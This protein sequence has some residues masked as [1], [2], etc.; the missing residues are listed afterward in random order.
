MIAR[1]CTAEI[2]CFDILFLDKERP[3]LLVEYWET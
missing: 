2:G 1:V 3:F